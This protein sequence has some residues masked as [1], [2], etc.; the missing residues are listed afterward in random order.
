M[1]LKVN[2][3]VVIPFSVVCFL[4]FGTSAAVTLGMPPTQAKSEQ[5]QG[6]I[7]RA[8]KIDA[9][10]HLLY[11]LKFSEARAQFAAWQKS[12]PE[13]PLAEASEAASYLFEE[14][15][16]QDVLTSE[17]FLDDDRFLGKVALKPDPALR[18]AFFAAVQ[19]AQDLARLRLQANPKDADTLFAMTLSMGLQADYASLI[20]MEQRESLR[21]LGEANEFAERLLAVAPE[22]ADAYLTLGLANYVVGSLSTF[23]RL[24]LRFSGIRGNKNLGVQQLK[25]AAASGRYLRPFAKIMLALVALREEQPELAHTKL[26]EL[27]AEY[28]ENPLFANE[29]AKLVS[30][31]TAEGRQDRNG[32]ANRHEVDDRFDRL[33]RFSIKIEGGSSL[34]PRASGFRADVKERKGRF[35]ARAKRNSPLGIPSSGHGPPLRASPNR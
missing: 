16:Q 8:P 35:R 14:C 13:D 21:M 1:L 34:L 10:F 11:Q 2:E 26:Q 32:P 12:H 18:T 9:G 30:G 24:F 27:V 19:R 3:R 17:F 29:L 4:I 33:V 5:N 6:G 22:A 28:P 15:Y 20:D 23:K 25:I 7:S 31:S